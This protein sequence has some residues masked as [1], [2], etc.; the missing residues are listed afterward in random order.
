MPRERVMLAVRLFVGVAVWFVLLYL[1]IMIWDDFVEATGDTVSE[2][3]RGKCGALGEF[4]DDHP[5][6]LLLLFLAG[7]AI[8]ALAIGWLLARLF[9]SLNARPD[10]DAVGSIQRS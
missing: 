4:T 10:K 1:G 3:D 9:P 8:P 5:L 6:I 2:C 7:T